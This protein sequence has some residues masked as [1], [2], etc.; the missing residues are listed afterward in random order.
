MFDGFSI[1]D[2]SFQ[3]ANAVSNL[4]VELVFETYLMY[5][6]PHEHLTAG[7]V[8]PEACL[9]VLRRSNIRLL[10]RVCCGFCHGGL[11]TAYDGSPPVL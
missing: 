7:R 5:T 8:L 3:V 6:T 1:H 2:V 10:K 4:H 9:F 11:E